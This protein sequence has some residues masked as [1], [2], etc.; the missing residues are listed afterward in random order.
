MLIEFKGEPK[1]EVLVMIGKGYVVVS[2]DSKGLLRFIRE[3]PEG[4]IPVRKTKSDETVFRV[5]NFENGEATY[6]SSGSHSGFFSINGHIYWSTIWDDISSSIY[7]KCS[8]E[9]WVIECAQVLAGVK[10]EISLT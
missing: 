7:K 3:A 4:Q 8:F 2:Y 9:D 1:S 5:T 10:K 6:K